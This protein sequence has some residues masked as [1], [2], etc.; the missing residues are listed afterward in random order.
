MYVVVDHHRSYSSSTQQSSS[1]NKSNLCTQIEIPNRTKC[2]YLVVLYRSVLVLFFLFSIP[3]I[4]ILKAFS[5]SL[6]FS[7]S[8]G[9]VRSFIVL[10]RRLSHS[11]F[12]LA[13]RSS[14]SPRSSKTSSICEQEK[15]RERER[16]SAFNAHINPERH[17]CYYYCYSCCYFILCLYYLATR[18]TRTTTASKNIYIQR[19]W[20]GG[21][22][23]A[24]ARQS[25]Q[26]RWSKTR[27]RREE[28]SFLFSY[29]FFYK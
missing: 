9:C 6:C 12:S 29:L 8:L 2:I 1:E 24:H 20:I 22:R 4:Y 26:T 17:W 5:L 7:F 19:R 21:W 27:R 15:E 23:N 14:S 13:S 11:C 16:T 28:K 25:S 18:T 10:R 3:Y